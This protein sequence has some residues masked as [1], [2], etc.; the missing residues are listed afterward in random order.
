MGGL[1]GGLRKVARWIAIVALALAAVCTFRAATVRAPAFDPGPPP[2]LP[3]VDPRIA[4]HL[5]AAIAIPT[6]SITSGGD[7]S[8]FTALHTLLRER[9]PRAFAALETT[10]IHEHA[11]VMRWAG[12]DTSARP[13]IL[14]AHTD[15]VPVEDGPVWTHPPFSGAIADDHVWGRGAMDDKL[16]VIGILGAIEALTST[17]F[18]PTRDVWIGFGHDEEVGGAAGAVAIAAW[19]QARGV[20]AQWLLD[21]GGAIVVGAIPGIESPIAFVGV[22]EKGHASLELVA[23]GEGGHS[24]MPPPGGAIARLS[25]AIVRL[26]R[27]PMPA[28]LRDPAAQMIDRLAPEQ[29]FVARLVLANRWM[30]DPLVERFLGGHPAT[31]AIVRTTTAPTIFDAGTADNV[32]ASRARAVVNF[33]VLPG[34]TVA[35]VE[36]HVRDVT[37]GLEIEVQCVDKCWDPSPV[38]RTQG[39]GWDTV[40]RAIGWTWPDVIISPSLVVGATDARHYAA[41][42]DD[43]Y[44]FLPLRML[45]TDRKR[46]HGTDERIAIANLHAAVRFY[47][48]VIVD[49]A[50]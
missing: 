39:E 20:K 26:E 27:E 25:E 5:S 19:L 37:D 29:T 2:T 15:V 10:A 41:V 11:L 7:P 49:A 38:S 44:R 33:R 6:I 22:A 24:S 21:E 50:D 42:A 8:S 48:S 28:D 13:I 40:G 3:D 14:I 46:L 36:A 9:F 31:N 1:A 43:S 35:D 4:E 30:F 17:G 12:S 18:V 47:M 23:T 45:D 16:G 32:L 34:E